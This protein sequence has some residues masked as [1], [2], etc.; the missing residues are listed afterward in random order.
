MVP[1][2]KLGYRIISARMSGVAAAKPFDAK[3]AAFEDP[4]FG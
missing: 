2:S 4:E 3:P 1:Q